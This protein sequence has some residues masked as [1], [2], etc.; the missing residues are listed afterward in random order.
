MSAYPKT[1]EEWLSS[2]HVPNSEEYWAL[3]TRGIKDWEKDPHV[4]ASRARS[5]FVY[6]VLCSMEKL[7]I[8]RVELAK[9]LGVNPSYITKALNE[10]EN[11]TISTMAR[12]ASV[13]GL[14]LDI[15]LSPAD[16]IHCWVERPREINVIRTEGWNKYGV[17]PTSDNRERPS[18]GKD[19]RVA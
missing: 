6:H 11:F 4:Q 17:S 5:L 3:F 2:D 1:F 16:A 12:F 7:G 15:N 13:L 9:D 10:Q 14:K 19:T 18:N 8:S